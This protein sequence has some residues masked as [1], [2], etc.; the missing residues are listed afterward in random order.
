MKK[1][2]L[3]I[4]AIVYLSTSLGATIHLHY[5]MGRLVSWGLTEHSG[6]S[7]G[8]CGMQKMPASGECSLGAKT[9]CHEESMQIRNDKDQKSAQEL[10][11]V[12][13][14][15]PAVADLPQPARMDAAIFSP[16]KAQP[17]S[18]GPP[19]MALVPVYLR[20]CNFRI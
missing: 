13:K 9:C 4:L 6:K 10:F 19:L 5:C 14:A 17:A 20:N 12:M 18:N 7:C 11:Q 15:A 1:V 16:V 8:F 3:S 2:L